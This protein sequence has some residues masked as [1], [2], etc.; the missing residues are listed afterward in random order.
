MG[1]LYIAFVLATGYIFTTLHL[2]A[3]HKVLKSQGW[4]PY[5]HVAMYGFTFFLVALPLL[6]YLDIK[7]Y[8]RPIAAYLGL[9][10][11]HFNEW[12][13]SLHE[14]KIIVWS[15]CAMFVSTIVGVL[16]LLLHKLQCIR[17]WSLKKS[18]RGDVIDSVIYNNIT[19]NQNKTEGSSFSYISITLKSRKVYVGL[20]NDTTLSSGGITGI[21][22]TPVLSGFRDKD[23][24]QIK[25]KTNYFDHYTDHHSDGKEEW[26]SETFNKFKVIMKMEE[27]ESISLFDID[28]YLKF[29]EKKVPW[30]PTN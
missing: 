21:K 20:C 24:L 14:A 30:H 27:V 9:R 6:L 7:D 25:Y 5:F 19:S 11:Y 13:V 26:N 4:V 8:A 1:V 3:N 29:Q 18:V 2:P 16:S 10:H 28:E 22:L 23:T 15:I 17:T 12:G